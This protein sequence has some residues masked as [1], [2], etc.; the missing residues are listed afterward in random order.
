MPYDLPLALERGLLVLRLLNARLGGV[1]FGEVARYL[2]ISN[3]S[4]MRL[5]VALVE[6]GYLRKCEQGLYHLGVQARELG[7]PADLHERLLRLGRGFL[8]RL[9]WRCRQTA[10]TVYYTGESMVCVDRIMVPEASPLQE[11]G[12]QVQDL[13]AAPWGWWFRS[14]EGWCDTPDLPAGKTGG[15]LAN[16]DEIITALQ[17]AQPDGCTV[18]QGDR[19]R[20]AAAVHLKERIVACICLGGT[21]LSLPPQL[22]PHCRE[23]LQQAAREFSRLLA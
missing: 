21:P 3:T 5:L 18:H 17:A 4:C 1:S 13:R 9:V 15:R 14:I 19:I 7:Q 10:I 11:V 16:N 8:D 22:L 12:H 2:G 20:L 23:Q 6:A